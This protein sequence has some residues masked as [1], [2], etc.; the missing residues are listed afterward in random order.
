L[1]FTTFSTTGKE[2]EKLETKTDQRRSAPFTM[3]ETTDHDGAKRAFTIS[4]MRTP[5]EVHI[6]PVR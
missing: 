5:S 2:E 4:E 6:A 3:P 1:E